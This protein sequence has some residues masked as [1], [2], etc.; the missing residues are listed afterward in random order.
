MAS[1]CTRWVRRAVLVAVALA[2]VSVGF[3]APAS[4]GTGLVSIGSGLKGRVGLSATVVAEG[5]S[6]VS[7]VAFDAD[8]RLWALTA[9][10]ED[11]GT[12]AL[13]VVPS[14]GATPVAVLTRLHTPMGLLWYDSWL[15]V[16]SGTTVDAYRGFGVD[17][18]SFAEHRT[19]LTLPGGVGLLGGLA[20]D[21]AGRLWLGASAPC[22]SCT[23]E[24]EYSAAI[25]SFASDGSDLRV[26]VSGVRA[27]VGLAYYP[28]T[29]DLFVT[30]N[31]RDDLDGKTPGDWLALVRAGEDWGFPSC[32]G[33]GGRACAGMGS[34]IAELD[35]H[36]AASGVAFDGT[37]AIVAE[38]AR[39][40]VLR[41]A[42][43][44]TASG[45]RASKTETWVKGI[46]QPVAVAVGPGGA[47]YVGDW[48]TGT[49]YRIA[50]SPES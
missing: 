2:V 24:S 26:D 41:V 14:T 50:E 36:A 33:Q 4:A 11:D 30:I 42:L 38:W 17:S 34:V 27:P 15:Y 49:V 35:T 20:V 16:A 28:G 37:S 13:Y 39:G 18:A 8:G 40:K 10:Y 29:D 48:A 47:V 6:N 22:D 9:R 3:E 32:Y 12:D 21:S 43:T 1:L 5:L 25:L 44:R 7:A 45:Y 19:V 46:K 23:P 31:Q